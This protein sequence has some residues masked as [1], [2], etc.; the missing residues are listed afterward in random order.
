MSVNRMYKQ[1]NEASNATATDLRESSDRLVWEMRNLRQYY[2]NRTP[3]PSSTVLN[4]PDLDND[5]MNDHY[6]RFADGMRNMGSDDGTEGCDYR[7]ENRLVSGRSPTSSQSSNSEIFSTDLQCKRKIIGSMQIANLHESPRRLGA[8]HSIEPSI[9]DVRK[10]RNQ[11]ALRVAMRSPNNFPRRAPGFPKVSKILYDITA[12]SIIFNHFS[13]CCP[14]PTSV[15]KIAMTHIKSP[16]IIHIKTST[17]NLQTRTSFQRRE[18]SSRSSSLRNKIS[19]FSSIG[20]SNFS[21]A[22]NASK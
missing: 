18:G 7:Y 1:P 12:E 21:S 20:L 4:S 6:H 3:T 17:R 8:S 15:K 5:R 13:E 11:E 22:A 10:E 19:S 2:H 14:H 16:S 9:H